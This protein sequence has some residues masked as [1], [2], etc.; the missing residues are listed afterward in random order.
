MATY[1]SLAVANELIEIAMKHGRPLTHMKLQK[2]L[3]FA[4][5]WNL[6]LAN[7]PLI[8]E[9]MQA[10]KFGPVAPSVY[11]ELRR[12][13]AAKITEPE[14]VYGFSSATNFSAPGAMSAPLT[15]VPRVPQQDKFTHQLLEKIW[16]VYGCYPAIQLTNMTHQEGTPWAQTIADFDPN[17]L[18]T[19]LVV[20]NEV[21]QQYFKQMQGK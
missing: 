6:A 11:Y 14:R 1:Q 18:P 12:Y 15:D 10:W 20:S 2:L 17:N 13:G 19:G 21:T 3:F 8:N 16:E 9:E 5:G 4:N 7:H